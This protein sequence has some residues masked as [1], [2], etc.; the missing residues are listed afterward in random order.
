MCASFA[1]W[2]FRVVIDSFYF[3]RNTPLFSLSKAFNLMFIETRSP[4]FFFYYLIKLCNYHSENNRYEQIW[5]Q[6][7]GTLAKCMIYQKTKDFLLNPVPAT[8]LQSL[9]DIHKINSIES[10]GH[11]G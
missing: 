5:E 4:F 3:N 10:M 8:S 7:Q 2:T 9:Q 11:V 6:I 1:R